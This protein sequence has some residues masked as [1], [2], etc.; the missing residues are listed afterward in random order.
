MSGAEG[1]TVVPDLLR[2]RAAEA[3][4]VVALRVGDSG[5]LTYGDWDRR[6]DAAAH[7]LLGRGV[8]PGD[9]VALLFP[10]AGLIDYA[11]A[12]LAVLKA[13][14][15]AVPLGSRFA[16]P[17]LE[18][19]LLHAAPAA[20]V[21]GASPDAGLPL[22]GAS[23][24]RP[25][26]LEDGPG[27][28]P[29][30]TGGS[31]DD[32]AEVLYTSGTTGTPKGVAC[33]HRGLLAHDL[34][35]DAAAPGDGPV[36]FLHAFPIGTQ[37]AQEALRV[38]LRIAGRVAQAM[39]V[40]D[41]EVLYALVARH[42]VVRLQLVPA[43]AQALVASGA[44]LRHDVSSLRRV[45]LSSAPAPPAL[46]G[47][48]AEALPGASLWNAY[49]LTEAGPARTMTEFDPARPTSVGR[50]VGA[51]E[52]RVVGD[53][54]APCPAGQ[55]G[56][57]WLRRP[58]SPSRTYYRDPAATAAVFV[59]GW[60]RTG[61]VGVLDPDGHLHL[62]DRR[63]DLVITGGANVSSVEVENALYEHPAVVEAAVFGVPHAVLG[64]DVAAA[65]VVRAAVTERELQ[66]VVRARLAEHKV[67]HR[68]A[69]V[70]E[71]PRN[72]SGKVVKAELRRRFAAAGPAAG[73]PGAHRPPG[74]PT[75]AVVASVWEAVLGLPR[76]GV[77]DDFFVLGGYSLAAAQ[78]AARLADAFGVEVGVAAVFEAPTVGELAG[79]VRRAVAAGT[80]AG[81]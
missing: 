23:T 48:L 65:V 26:E 61:D 66:D 12:Y 24:L 15:V 42:R 9:R 40:F 19:V 64:E 22:A 14:A 47:R 79:V 44:H 74:D 72:A 55:P 75:E 43:M 20:I 41:P 34:P 50:P 31:A 11:V 51:T 37:A 58:G 2:R 21:S 32:L 16:G 68:L 6:S 4:G 38:P 27:G 17:E 28:P 71:L 59:G 39:P 53:D 30:A 62:V 77:D 73:E 1:A 29:P 67:P 36:T 25:G 60:V 81:A 52:V 46:F 70:D 18:I 35:A 49:A 69:L 10:D 45:I 57:V 56:E 8:R 7:G 80:P 54:G 5:E 63:K 13:G 3:A 78:I 76:V 33:T